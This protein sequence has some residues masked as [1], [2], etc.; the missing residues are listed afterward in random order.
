MTV[1]GTSVHRVLPSTVAVMGL[2]KTADTRK[3]LTAI[4]MTI[5]AIC[6]AGIEFLSI[7]FTFPGSQTN[8]LRLAEYKNNRHKG[9]L[10]YSLTTV[11]S[12][13]MQTMDQ[14]VQSNVK[15]IL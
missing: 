14:H 9:R 11:I 15:E 1:G 13:Q 6:A 5:E 12:V 8:R 4:M 10:R 7:Y 2:E 3:K